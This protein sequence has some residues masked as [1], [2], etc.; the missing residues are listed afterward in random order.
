[1]KRTHD[2][3]CRC[4]KCRH[5][6]FAPGAPSG[7]DAQGCTRRKALGK[8]NFYGH[9]TY[10]PKQ[11]RIRGGESRGAFYGGMPQASGP[12]TF[13]APDFVERAKSTNKYRAAPGLT[14]RWLT[15]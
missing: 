3:R 5:A 15:P 14:V 9:F 2:E 12:I 8:A 11:P 6:R 10:H 4:A 1:M 13:G 7:R